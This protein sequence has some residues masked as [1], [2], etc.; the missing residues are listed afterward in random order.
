MVGA[1][2]VGWGSDRRFPDL[3]G[4]HMTDADADI[5]DF[6]PTGAAGLAAW[7]A[8]AEDNAAGLGRRLDGLEPEGREP[9]PETV[10]QKPKTGPAMQGTGRTSQLPER[11]QGA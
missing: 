5:D 3:E 9:T 2:A 1:T 4:T 8:R 11:A 6:R 7:F 10:P